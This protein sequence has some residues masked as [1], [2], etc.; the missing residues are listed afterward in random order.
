MMGGKEGDTNN[1]DDDDDDEDEE[2]KNVVNIQ[3]MNSGYSDILKKQMAHQQRMMQEAAAQ[4]QGQHPGK[5]HS[6]PVTQSQFVQMHPHLQQQTPL[7]Q[8]PLTKLQQ[9]HQQQYQKS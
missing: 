3:N 9:Y 7:Q 2:N 1:H 4:S 8:Q 5:G 6:R